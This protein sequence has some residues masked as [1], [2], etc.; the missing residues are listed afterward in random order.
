MACPAQP[1]LLCDGKPAK[2]NMVAG[3]ERKT[4]AGRLQWNSGD[5]ATKDEGRPWQRE[6]KQGCRGENSP[7]RNRKDQIKQ[8]AIS[9]ECLRM[10]GG[11][12]NNQQAKLF[13]KIMWR[14]EITQIKDG[15]HFFF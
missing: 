4:T 2:Q 6:E 14:S 1:V 3:T 8:W 15:P 12:L 13:L 11:N 9:R 5:S 10:G 7:E